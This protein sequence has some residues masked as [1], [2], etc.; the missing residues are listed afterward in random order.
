LASLWAVDPIEA[1]L[2]RSAVVKDTDGIA[3]CDADNP[4]SKLLGHSG[5]GKPEDGDTE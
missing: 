3:V 5:R 2:F 4:A 1:D